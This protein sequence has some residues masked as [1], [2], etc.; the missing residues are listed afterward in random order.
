MRVFRGT[1]CSRGNYIWVKY[2]WLLRWSADIIGIWGGEKTTR[3]EQMKLKH[4]RDP[5]RMLAD[6][7]DNTIASFTLEWLHYER[8]GGRGDKRRERQRERGRESSKLATVVAKFLRMW[9]RWRPTGNLWEAG[10]GGEGEMRGLQR[11]TV[12]E[13]VRTPTHPPPH[14]ILL[15]VL[16]VVDL[17][18]WI[19]HRTP[20]ESFPRRCEDAEPHK[21]NQNK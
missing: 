17:H 14:A 5:G 4:N 11:E 15:S 12:N 19:K 8:E 1:H 18:M 13:W 20:G 3:E 2:L 10:G 9:S 16:H 7:T 6:N 21:K